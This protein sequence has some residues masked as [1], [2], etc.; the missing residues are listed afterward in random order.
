MCIIVMC[1]FSLLICGCLVFL[2]RSG[3]VQAT[4]S[5]YK[6]AVWSLCDPAIP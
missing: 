1:A 6:Q 3:I 5:I 4:N 2:R